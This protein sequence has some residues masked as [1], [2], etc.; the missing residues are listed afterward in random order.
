MDESESQESGICATGEYG[1]GRALE[2]PPDEADRIRRLSRLYAI[3]KGLILYAEEVDPDSRSNLQIIKELR[4]AFD[5]LMRIML[6]RSCGTVPDG[7]DDVDYYCGTNIDK[8][9]GHVYR[10][11]FD[12]LDGTILSLKAKIHEILEPYN[13]DCIKHVVPDYWEHRKSLERLA[14]QVASHRAEKDVGKNY[15]ALFDEYVDDV[16]ILSAF[17]EELLDAMPALDEYSQKNNQQDIIKDGRAFRV[18]L[19][20]AIIGGSIIAILSIWL[21]VQFV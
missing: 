10:A 13:L 19:K 2:F 5:H 18:S 3:A 11:A 21:T 16:K 9:V 8:A 1:T 12:A 15:G 14:K 6:A 4:D 17:H 7:V 20:S